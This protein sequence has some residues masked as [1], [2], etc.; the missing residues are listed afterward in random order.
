MNQE[1]GLVTDEDLHARKGLRK[2]YRGNYWR[3]KDVHDS[4][5]L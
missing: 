1:L 2:T 3:L 5:L 4:C